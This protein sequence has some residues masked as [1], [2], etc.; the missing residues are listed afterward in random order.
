MVRSTTRFP[1]LSPTP[2]CA[3]VSRRHRG[4]GFLRPQVAAPRALRR[5]CVAQGKAHRGGWRPAVGRA[6]LRPNGT[7]GVFVYGSGTAGSARRGGVQP[8]ERD[9]VRLE[10]V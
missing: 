6:G 3:C 2:N 7:Q 10:S 5:S 8:G 4:T 1:A 9:S